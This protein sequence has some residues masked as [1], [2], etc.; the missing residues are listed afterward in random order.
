[1]GPSSEGVPI[2]G[3][4][5]NVTQWAAQ[6]WE[7]CKRVGGGGLIWCWPQQAQQMA[8]SL[9]PSLCQ[10]SGAVW[11]HRE[12]PSAGT[13]PPTGSHDIIGVNISCENLRPYHG[14]R[15][16][17]SPPH[18]GSLELISIAADH[19]NAAIRKMVSSDCCCREAKNTQGE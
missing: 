9:V 10:T 13:R 19:S 15:L 4:M 11:A 17:S 7:L 3:A 5:T 2:S 18:A 8:L 6:G 12:R 14:P 16:T 1:M